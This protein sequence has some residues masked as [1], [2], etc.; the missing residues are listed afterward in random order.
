MTTGFLD[1]PRTVAVLKADAGDTPSA[2]HLGAQLYVSLDGRVR[3]DGAVGFDRPGEPLTPGH[4]MLWLSATKPVTAVAFARLWEEGEV[5]LDDPVASVIPEFAAGGKERVTF[6]HLLTHTSGIRM[7]QLGF[8]QASWEEILRKIYDRRLEPRWEPGE[9][10]GYHMGSSWFV[11]GEAIARLSGRPFPDFVRAEVFEPLGMDDSY[12][13]MPAARYQRYEADHRVARWWNTTPSE[14]VRPH[15]WHK[16]DQVTG[17]SPG[18]NGRGPMRQ[19]GRFYE[20]LLAG[21]TLDGERIL[22]PQTVEAL[23]AR[24]RVGVH[25]HTFDHVLDWGLGF[26][27]NSNQYGADTVPY[28]Y[29]P[30]AS[31]RTY[32]HSGYR[33]VVAFADPKHRLAVALAWNGTPS[34]EAHEGRVRRTLGA[35]YED[36]GL[37]EGG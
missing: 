31:R 33:S 1:L 11:L 27:V 6:R 7:V 34:N 12:I 29:G 15:R 21:G 20:M 26:I 23:T 36:L 25:D 35:L 24:H 8:P 30:Y 5:G 17:V 4:L 10:A 28:A 9:K 37:A 14:E 16:E 22:S 32:G 2:L 19:L 3:A 18:G 13:G